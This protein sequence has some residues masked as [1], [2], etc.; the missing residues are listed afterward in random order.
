M[1]SSGR[2]PTTSS[3]L[4]HASRGNGR[5]VSPSII[6]IAC[7]P[8]DD[9]VQ[10]G[11]FIGFVP[12]RTLRNINV[13]V[14]M[15]RKKAVWEISCLNVVTQE[16]KRIE[17]CD[18]TSKVNSKL[19]LGLV[20]IPSDHSNMFRKIYNCLN[21]EPDLTFSSSWSPNFELNFSHVWRKSSCSNFAGLRQH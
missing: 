3:H 9:G 5:L 11:I 19:N 7:L 14:G 6:N 1:L 15:I 16:P 17:I 8:I 18:K 2:V 21:C 13:Q 10:C 4:F 20:H 12:R